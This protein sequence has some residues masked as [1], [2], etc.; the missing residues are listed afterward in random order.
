VHLFTVAFAVNWF[1]NCNV[2]SAS[3]PVSVDSAPRLGVYYFLSLTLHCLSVCMSVCMSV[4]VLLQ[5][6]SFLFL[7][8]IE[9]FFW[10]SVLHVALYKTVFFDFWFRPLNPKSYSPKFGTKSPIS[11]LVWQIDQRCLGLLGVFWGW[12]IQW[13]HGKC[14]G[15]DPCCHGNEI[16][17]NLG[18]FKK[19]TY[20]S[21]C[22]PDR[23]DMFGPTR[24]D[25]HGDRSL[26]PW[27]WHL[28]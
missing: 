17:A 2:A 18:Y 20:K 13:N 14:C 15:A 12:P 22:M 19:V 4:T 23:Q 6:T 1:A 5:I 21:A 28:C 9:P 11:R 24:G 26:L 7:D 3:V 16:L 25:D 10:P 27:Q 8:G